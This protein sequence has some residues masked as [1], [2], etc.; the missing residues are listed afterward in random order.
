MDPVWQPCRL[1]PLDGSSTGRQVGPKGKCKSAAWSPDGRWMYFGAEVAGSHHLWRQRF[2]KGEPEQITFGP[3]EEQGVAVA[4]DGRS[5]LTSIGVHQSAIWIH[6]ARGERP[7]SSDG[8]VAPMP[9][10]PYL[11][12]KFS[13]DGK[14]LFYLMRRDSPASA[15]G[16]WKIDLHSG[17][18]EPLLPGVSMVE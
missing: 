13:R 17:K 15:S 1:V 5:L 8:Y 14:S 16:L 3:T 6:D 18:S 9:V 10:Y 12:L 11:S 2:P 4:P 7:L